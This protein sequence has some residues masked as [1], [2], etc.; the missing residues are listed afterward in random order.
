MVSGLLCALHVSPLHWNDAARSDRHA[1]N[2][3]RRP[4]HPEAARGMP[5]WAFGLMGLG[6]VALALGY[7]LFVDWITRLGPRIPSNAI[8]GARGDRL[9]DH[10][11]GEDKIPVIVA[12]T[13]SAPA[14]IST[15]K[16]GS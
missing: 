8:V 4:A 12:T 3:D 14:W 10:F 1:A 16:S 7:T 2:V 11:F 5:F 6:F 9:V 13:I 15:Q